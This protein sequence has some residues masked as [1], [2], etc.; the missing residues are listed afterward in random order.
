MKTS[1]AQ[2]MGFSWQ[3]YDS[4]GW[5]LWERKLVYYF[6]HL[7]VCFQKL[8]CLWFMLLLWYRNSSHVCLLPRLKKF[9]WDKL[10]CCVVIL[11]AES[12]PTLCDP[13]DCSPPSSSVHGISQARILKWVAVSFSGGSSQPRDWSWVS[14][15]GRWIYQGSPN[16]TLAHHLAHW[17]LNKC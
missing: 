12:C 16:S 6:L 17:E 2:K 14:C 13:V 7:T 11:N 8:T 3:W 1:G 15:V 10:L 4:R 5:W 9:K